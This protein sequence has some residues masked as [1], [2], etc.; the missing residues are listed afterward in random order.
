[1]RIALFGGSFDP[2]HDAH[3]ALASVALEHL[4]LDRLLWVPVGDAWQKERP[5]A[6]ARH[7]AAMV[8]LAI[9]AE[10]RCVLETIEVERAGP[11]Y[12]IDTVRELQAREPHA[13]WWLVLGQDQYAN[14]HTWR[15][16]RD[17]ARRVVFAVAGRAGDEPRA[18]TELAPHRHQMVTL[19][20][21]PMN[22]SSTE[23]RRRIAHG[24][25]IDDMVPPAVARYIDLHHLYR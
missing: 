2:V 1:M 16:W 24:E 7:R 21:P 6:P 19:A 3:L 13:Q 10:P 20:L 11:S 15:D 4:A 23:I 12:T 14:L 9:A 5:L 8:S 25:R 18:G 22:V 17:L